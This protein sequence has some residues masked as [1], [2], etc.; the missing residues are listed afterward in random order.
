MSLFKGVGLL[1]VLLLAA[2][3]TAYA[4][5]A[6]SDNNIDS[7]SAD[8]ASTL[9]IGRVTDNPGKSYWKLYPAARYVADQLADL[10]IVSV[11]VV[12]A[13]TL[14]E[15]ITL[16]KTGRV[17]WVTES[18]YG[19]TRYIDE[20]GAEP[21]L[22]ERG[23]SIAGYRSVI[24]ARADAGITSLEDL[25]GKFVV[26]EDSSSTSGYFIPKAELIK[27][28]FLLR[29]A[30][31]GSVTLS[32]NEI[33]YFFS[34]GESNSSALVYMG[35]VSAAALSDKDWNKN[36]VLPMRQREYLQIIHQSDSYP[37]RFELVRQG[38]DPEVKQ[39]IQQVL[40]ASPQNPAAFD[41]LDAY[42]GEGG[43]SVLQKTH[44]DALDTIRS[45]RRLTGD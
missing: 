15:M 12:M 20:A 40:L 5:A 45:L 10:G 13:S 28:G 34:G 19:A 2:L 21:I 18:V 1:S 35:K 37:S 27:A 11:E 8:R 22:V 44:Y 4:F 9:V 6:A 16:L 31:P 17:D 36:K 42:P 26:F 25:G 33:G 39:G 32:D 7:V 41:A 23:R 3:M 30:Q 38:L 24:F 14:E 29:P 43:F